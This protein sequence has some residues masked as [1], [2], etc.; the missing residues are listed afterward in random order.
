MNSNLKLQGTAVVM[1]NDELDN[2]D[3]P[4]GLLL[5]QCN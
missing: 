2:E 1:I 5:V 4:G 3:T